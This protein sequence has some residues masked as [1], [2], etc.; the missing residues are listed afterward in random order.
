M[1]GHGGH[2]SEYLGRDIGKRSWSLRHGRSSRPFCLLINDWA[3]SVEMANR[4]SEL[5]KNV[6]LA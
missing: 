2:L 5:D 1:Q 6:H 3:L 4:S